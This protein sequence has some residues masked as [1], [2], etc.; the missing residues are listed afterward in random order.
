[1]AR[2][3]QELEQE[4]I[5]LKRHITI[6][7]KDKGHTEKQQETNIQ[8][9]NKQ[10]NK[11]KVTRKDRQLQQSCDQQQQKEKITK[12]YKPTG[13]RIYERSS[14]QDDHG[15]A[16]SSDWGPP[17]RERPPRR[18]AA[19]SQPGKKPTRL[20]S[21]N[22]ETLLVKMR[23]L[24]RAYKVGNPRI[25][26]ELNKTF[27]TDEEYSTAPRETWASV[28]GRRKKIPTNRSGI[29]DR[30]KQQSRPAQQQAQ[31]TSQKRKAPRTAAVAI[32]CS[33]P[34]DY[35][36]VLRKARERISLSELKI[37][38]TKTR[39]AINGGLI[40]EISGDDNEEKADILANRLREILDTKVKI[41]RPS[42]RA[43]IRIIGMDD[44]ASAEE[45]A[46]IVSTIGGC[47][48][49]DIK[50]GEIKQTNRGLGSILVQC[51]L[52]SAIKL[53]NEGKIQVG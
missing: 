30:A 39:R 22:E 10:Q 51:P 25:M 32:Q 1:M 19:I 27:E 18:R 34:D 36:T 33:N 50:T 4:K 23:E 26:D 15:V 43:A 49:A 45:I 31:K 42:K 38:I 37:Q 20:V 13:S 7:E 41:T 17:P 9:V 35:P 6:M 44:S 29:S 8:E 16:E 3:I 21:G 48:I 40:I 11:N 2:K 12:I 5:D 52:S 46:E 24:L 47:S 28:V 53:A 14:M